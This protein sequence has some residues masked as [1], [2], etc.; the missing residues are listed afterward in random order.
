MV[1]PPIAWA[2]QLQLEGGGRDLAHIKLAGHVKL[3]GLALRCSR[4]HQPVKVVVVPSPCEAYLFRRDQAQELHSACLGWRLP[5]LA[6]TRYSSF[7]RQTHYTNMLMSF[8][9][10]SSESGV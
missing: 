9:Q 8:F 4:L 1:S 2:I 3:A 6:A 10:L 7:G 5:G